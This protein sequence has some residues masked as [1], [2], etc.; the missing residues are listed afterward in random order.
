MTLSCKTLGWKALFGAALL[1]LAACSTVEDLIGVDTG[2]VQV[3]CSGSASLP[4][5]LPMQMSLGPLAPGTRLEIRRTAPAQSVLLTLPEGVSG[6]VFA[7]DWKEVATGT[8][9]PPGAWLCRG[10]WQYDGKLWQL[11]HLDAQWIGGVAR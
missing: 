9:R 3:S 8:E 5:A 7:Y 2:T 1:P 4:A 11:Q 6:D 10:S